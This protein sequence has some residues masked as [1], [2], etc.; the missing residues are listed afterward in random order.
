MDSFDFVFL[1]LYLSLTGY[2][3]KST[4]YSFD[5]EVTI[6]ITDKSDL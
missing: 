4:T 2:L 3:I 1:T 6:H 5:E